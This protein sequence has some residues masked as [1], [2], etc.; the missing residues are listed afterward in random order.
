MIIKP[1]KKHYIYYSVAVVI[2]LL[3][4]LLVFFVA[5]TKSIQMSIII[6]MTILF[7]AWG[8]IH[9]YFHH[10]LHPKVVIE[11]VLMGTLGI[12]LAFFVLN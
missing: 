9:H 11:Y 8:L 1:F 12:S 7:T 10:D 6:F 4:F 3:G 2:Q 5:D